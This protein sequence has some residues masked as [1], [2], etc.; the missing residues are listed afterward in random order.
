MTDNRKCFTSLKAIDQADIVFVFFF[1]LF[2]FVFSCVV[3][4]SVVVAL[5]WLYRCQSDCTTKNENTGIDFLILDL[6]K[7]SHLIGFPQLATQALHSRK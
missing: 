4:V 3:K 6:V 5:V 7:P 2:L 1:S